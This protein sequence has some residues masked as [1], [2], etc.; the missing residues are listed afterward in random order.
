M[1]GLAEHHPQLS[2]SLFGDVPMPI[3][4]AGLIGTRHQA[5]V[6]GDVLRAREPVHIG[7]DRDGR[8]RHDRADPR[9]RLEPAEIVP[10]LTQFAKEVNQGPDLLAR[11]LPDR[12]V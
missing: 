1:R 5:G 8:Q 2:G 12:P 6:A 11:V 10:A 3:H 4:G 7:E 9:Y